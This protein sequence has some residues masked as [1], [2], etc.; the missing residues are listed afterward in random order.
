MFFGLVG[1]S[2]AFG[3]FFLIPGKEEVQD[4]VSSIVFIM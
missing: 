2:A 1:F 4:F 3:E